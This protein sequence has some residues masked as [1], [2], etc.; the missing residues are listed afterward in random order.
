MS[1]TENRNLQDLHHFTG[2]HESD[3]QIELSFKNF[4]TVIEHD[5][6]NVKNE[7]V[8]FFSVVQ[9]INQQTSV[10]DI[11]RCLELIRLPH[12]SGDFLVDVILDHQ[13]MIDPPREKYSGEV[14]LY[15][16]QKHQH[17]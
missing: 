17:G 12:T 3:P 14:I 7:D 4:M 6:I 15:Q 16:V 10:E 13:L 11:N 2:L 9:I 5:E 1:K 8:I